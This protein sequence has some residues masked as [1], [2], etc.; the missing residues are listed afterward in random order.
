MNTNTLKLSAAAAAVA[1][2]FAMPA[3]AAVIVG[4]G[5]S[6][7]SAGLLNA[8]LNDDCT[9]GTIQFYDNSTSAPT[10]SKLTNGTVFAISCTPVAASRFT[11]STLN[12]SYDTTGGSWKAF[13]AT[14]PAFF[15]SAQSAYP[16]DPVSP[17]KAIDPALPT[18]SGTVANYSSTLSNG[19]VTNVTYNWGCTPSLVDGAAY[20]Y[21]TN[22]DTPTFGITD[23]EPKLFVNS[24]ENQPLQYLSWNTGPVPL[25]SPFTLGSEYNG[26]G[27]GATGGIKVFGVTTGI[28]VSGP[29][30][31]ALQNDQ[32]LAGILPSSCGTGTSGSTAI[33]NTSANC[34]PYIS[35]SQ[36]ASTISVSGGAALQSAALL[37]Q[38]PSAYSDLSYEWARRD[39]G[40]GTQSAVNAYFLNDGCSTSATESPDTTNL[41]ANDTQNGGPDALIITYNPSNTDAQQRLQ[42][43]PTTISGVNNAYPTSNFVIA[44][45]SGTSY[46]STSIAGTASFGSGSSSTPWGFLRLEGFLPTVANVKAGLYT[47][48]YTEFLHCSPSAVGDSAKLCQDLGGLTS[49]ATSLISFSTTGSTGIYPIAAAN[50]GVYANGGKSCSGLRHL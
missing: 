26:F 31:A 5:A 32:L 49:G 7:S 3:K 11:S 4:A 2:V 21:G 36:Y 37:F 28:A 41:P 22:S 48:A 14:T 33:V 35:K 46:S 45:I 6:A 42:G 44:T 30:Y 12:V 10:N 29:L 9:A 40:S 16:G 47:L 24:S 39:R 18:C 20:G 8:I 13:T 34:A 19:T 43:Y 15:A 17:V 50:G 23:T 1:A 38:N 25:I 27:S